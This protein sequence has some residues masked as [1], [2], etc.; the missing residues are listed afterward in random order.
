MFKV[1]ITTVPFAKKNKLPLELL[2]KAGI[3]YLINPLN[4]KLT[5]EELSEMVSGFDVIIAGT[6]N[7]SKKVMN[8]ANKLKHISR[9]GIGL[10]SVDLLE[11]EKKDIKV[12]YTPDAPAPAVSELTIGLMLTLLRS[13]HVSNL[14]MHNGNWN[15]IF[16]RRLSKVIIG[17]IGVGRIGT[18]VINHLQGF[19]SPKILANDISYNSDKFNLPIQW[20]DKEQIFKEADIITIHLPL[21]KLTKDLIK[22]QELLSMKKNA[23]I[24]NTSRGGIVNEKDLCSVMQIGHLSGAAIDVYEKEPYIGPLTGIERCLLTSHMGSMSVDCRSRMEIE[25]T[26]EAIR[27]LTGKRL[28]SEVPEEEYIV[29]KMDIS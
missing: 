21:T 25:A 12:S 14:Q 18:R 27:F 11:A 3:E 8:K 2:Q 20:A 6:E 16:G 22:K 15:R 26:E 5:E 23:I 28:E 29:Q 24:I 9:V 19:G 7:I 10:D 13:V 17:I 1:L 4:K